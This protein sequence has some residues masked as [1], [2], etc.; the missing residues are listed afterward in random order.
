MIYPKFLRKSGS[1]GVTAV[2]DGITGSAK[3]YRLDN[4]IS[5]CKDYLSHNTVTTDWVKMNW[6]IMSPAVKAHRKYLVDDIHHARIIED[7]EALA[8]LQAEYYILSPYIEL[9]KTFPKFLQ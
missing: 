5:K 2:S 6:A 9:F 3:L 7:K 4:A 1:I 8:K